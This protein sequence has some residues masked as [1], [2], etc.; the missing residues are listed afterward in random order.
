VSTKTE[1][2]TVAQLAPL[3]QFHIRGILATAELVR[4]A[5]LDAFARVLDLDCSIGSPARHRPIWNPVG[6]TLCGE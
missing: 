1:A 4:A 3:D 2:L 6:A 5:R